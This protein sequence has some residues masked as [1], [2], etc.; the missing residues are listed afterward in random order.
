MSALFNLM[1]KVPSNA[2]RAAIMNAAVALVTAME[3]EADK[4]DYSAGE[5]EIFYST[6]VEGIQEARRM[7]PL[8]GVVT[9]DSRI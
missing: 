1:T 3:T 2:K 4:E 6:V 7:L 5:R 8:N 9:V